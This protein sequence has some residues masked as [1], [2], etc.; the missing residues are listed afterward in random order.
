[1]VTPEDSP[2]SGGW[3]QG[4]ALCRAPIY[5]LTIYRLPIYR[6]RML[7]AREEFLDT[8]FAREPMRRQCLATA[9]AVC[10]LGVAGAVCGV[11]VVALVLSSSAGAAGG[12]GGG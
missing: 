3:A 1:M 11:M 10:L 9:L 8:R 4:A 7:P 5:C 6:G 2:C 12:C